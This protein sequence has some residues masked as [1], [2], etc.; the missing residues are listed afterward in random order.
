MEAHLHAFLTPVS[1]LGKWSASRP[2]RFI[3]G[4]SAPGTHWIG[5]LV[6]PRGG[7]DAVGRRED[8][9]S[10]RESNPGR[11]ARSLITTLTELQI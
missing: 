8:P 11:P 3:P 5:G 2:D 10:C 6:S 9:C 4:E 1:D 7:L